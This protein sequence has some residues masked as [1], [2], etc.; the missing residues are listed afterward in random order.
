MHSL[1]SDQG[2]SHVKFLNCD[3]DCNCNCALP[4]VGLIQR[5]VAVGSIDV[6]RSAVLIPADDDTML[7]VFAKNLGI[8]SWICGGSIEGLFAE[9]IDIAKK[10]EVVRK[11]TETD[12]KISIALGSSIPSEIVTGIGFFDHMLYQLAKHGGMSIRLKA[13]GD[14]HIDTHHLIEDTAIVIGTALRKLIGNGFGLNRFGFALP[15]DEAAAKVLIDLSG[16]PYSVFKANFPSHR[17]GGL[18]TEMVGHFFR[19]LAEALG[20]SLH[21]DLLGSNSHH[22]VE[23]AFKAVGRALKIALQMD[24]VSV[25]IP[26]T[27]GVL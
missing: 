1:P 26:S 14:L 24:S 16:R 20:A 9:L 15:M 19:S 5:E 13:I 8:K 2:A 7:A 25:G 10:V 3:H 27:K 18:D 4:N 21:I 12:I 6:L 17:V 11:T 22:M 23:A